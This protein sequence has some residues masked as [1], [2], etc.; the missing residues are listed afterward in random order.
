MEEDQHVWWQTGI[1]YQV[2]P[3]SF[4]DSNGDGTRDKDGKELVLRFIASQ[5]QIRKD[6]QAVVQQSPCE[7]SP[8][9][10]VAHALQPTASAWPATC[11]EC[12][13][14]GTWTMPLRI[15]VGGAAGPSLV[16]SS[17]A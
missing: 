6:V 14:P 10:A 8:H 11:S 9:T 3:R 16:A 1:L 17:F 12:A 15:N 5:R 2:Y 13:Q 7:P 4:K